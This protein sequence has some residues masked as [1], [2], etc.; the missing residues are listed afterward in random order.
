MVHN[1]LISNIIVSTL[2]YLICKRSSCTLCASKV[3]KDVI[4]NAGMPSST[5]IE[6]Q[7]ITREP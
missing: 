3:G 2:S 7:E 5:L 6:P 4:T 1:F